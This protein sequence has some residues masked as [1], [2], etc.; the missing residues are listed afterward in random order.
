VRRST[1]GSS[2]ASRTSNATTTSGDQSV[3]PTLP[4]SEA[5]AQIV[6]VTARS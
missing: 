5:F 1:T 4:D 2:P 3:E 6:D